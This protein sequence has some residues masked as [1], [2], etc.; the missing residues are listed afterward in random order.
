MRMTVRT[1]AAALMLA[2]TLT[3]CATVQSWNPFDRPTPERIASPSVPA[4][5]YGTEQPSSYAVRG[6]GNMNISELHYAVE[7]EHIAK[8][9]SCASEPVAQLLEKGPGYET[10]SIPC[11]ETKVMLIKCEFSYCR[12]LQ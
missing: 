8:D 12:T 10:Y 4:S 1:L 11:G 3:G 5:S 6:T 9:A 2:M 7:S